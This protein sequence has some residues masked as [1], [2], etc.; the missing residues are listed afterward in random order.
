MMDLDD[1]DLSHDGRPAPEVVP[2]KANLEQVAGEIQSKYSQWRSY[3]QAH[4]GEWLVTAAMLRNQQHVHY[5]EQRG[6]L[7]GPDVPSYAVQIDLNKITPKH[8][9]RMAKKFKNRPKPVVV[10]ASTDYQ[11]LMDARASE[12]ALRYQTQRLRLESAY[13]DAAQWSAIGS[14]S[15]WWF[16]Y[17]P[18]VPGRVKIT[19]PITGE[20]RIETVELGDVTVEVGSAFEVL[21]PDPSLARIGQQPEIM[22]VRAIER[23]EAERRFPELRSDSAAY[24]GSGDL[25]TLKSTEDRIAS[26]SAGSH[27]GGAGK[28]DS[29]VLLIEHYM[30]PC[31][32]YPKGRK[33]VVCGSTVV[34]YDEELPFEFWDSPTNPYPCSEF[35]DTGHVGQFWNATWLS[36]LIPLQRTLNRMLELVVEN[37]EAV[38]RP[39]LVVYQQHNL[40]DGAWT[41]AAGE[42]VTLTH[43]PGLPE[44][45][46]VAPPSVAGDV[47]NVINLTLR[48]F[49]DIS[50][51]HTASEGGGT[52]QESGY[53]TNLLQEATDAVHAPDIRGDELTIEDAAWKIRRIMKLTW[54]VP[55]LITIGGEHSASEMLEFS[56]QQINDAAEVRIQIGSMLP[57]LKAAKAQTT[58]NYYKEGVFGDPTDPMVR[59]KVLAQMDMLGVDIIHEE[60]R[61]DEDEAT[62]ESQALMRGEPVA[63]ATFNQA[64][65]VHRSKHEAKMK[66]PEW[67]LLPDEVKRAYIA[68][69]ITHYDWENLPLAMGLRSQYDLMT[70]PIASP[71]PPDAMGA[72]P[73]GPTAPPSP[74]PGAPA[75]P[76]SGPPA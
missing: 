17:D 62:R 34:R 46:F 72:P 49:D 25:S 56:R 21:V 70:L 13:R 53:Q 2:P 52:G 19:D 7:V 12:C 32:K 54:D 47:W 18:L 26:L 73:A 36:H 33:A 35:A 43:I 76:P 75:P 4:E 38:S 41:S 64:H 61:L 24:S 23:S 69:I 29:Q 28:R 66:T 74:A 60:D 59:R 51:I 48:Q 37:A 58:L 16:G 10:P 44:P 5:D 14:K 27:A 11:D 20:D 55:R 30:A 63:P 71:P 50:Q 22:R 1:D 3:R 42:V 9:A 67:H 31:G 57:D 40:A 68:H 65:P 45:R 15:Y 6:A 8:R 39:K